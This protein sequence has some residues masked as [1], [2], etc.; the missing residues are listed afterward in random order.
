MKGG[1]KEHFSHIRRMNEFMRLHPDQNLLCGSE[2]TLVEYVQKQ[3]EAELAKRQVE[4]ALKPIVAT[5]LTGHVNGLTIPLPVPQYCAI[6]IDDGLFTFS[7]LVAKSVAYSFEPQRTVNGGSGYR[8]SDEIIVKKNRGRDAPLSRFADVLWCYLIKGHPKF[9][10][11]N[12]LRQEYMSL[13]TA[14]LFGMEFFLVS[15]EYGHVALGHLRRQGKSLI[16]K[17]DEALVIARRHEEEFEADA[18]A[19]DV[20]LSIFR[21]THSIEFLYGGIECFLQMTAIIRDAV[22]M[23]TKGRSDE[24]ASGSHPSIELRK[25]HLR[26][27][28]A[29]YASE[30]ECVAAVS[31]AETVERIVDAYWAGTKDMFLDAHRSGMTVHFGKAQRLLAQVASSSASK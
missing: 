3:V 5:A 21:D 8:I 4:L 7:M 9:A 11:V 16:E 31:F 17:H 1:L 28:L 10:R 23:A 25:A 13:Y 27:K 22:C 6:L 14:L 2:A 20:T 24:L 26:T 12:R 19:L 18:Y 15:H 30:A 29:Q